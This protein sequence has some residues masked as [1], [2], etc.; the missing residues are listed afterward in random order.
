M[1][2]KFIVVAALVAQCAGFSLAAAAA[3]STPI[4]P[5]D[6]VVAVVNDDVIT[7]RDLDAQTKMAVHQLQQQNTQLPPMD[8][9]QKQVLERMINERILVQQAKQ[10]GV[11]IDDTQLDQALQRIAAQSRMSVAEFRAAL[12]K[13][14]VSFADFREDIRNEMM[15]GRLRDHEVDS[16]VTVSDGEVQNFLQAYGGIAQEDYRIGHIL[17]QLPDQAS[18]DQIEA[19]RL[20]AEA[21]RTELLQGKDFKQ[22]AAAY[23]D[24]PDALQGGIV[25]RKFGQL[26]G[27][28]QQTVQNMQS[29]DVSP[30]L[31]SPNGF[32]VLKLI[33]KSDQNAPVVVEQT[34]ARHILMRPTEVMSDA[35]VQARLLQI[36]ERILNGAKFEE[37]ARLNSVDGSASRGGD[38]GWLSPGDTVPEFE[39]AM[40]ALKPGEISMPIHSQFGWHLIQV[41]ERRQQDVTDNRRKM[42]ARMALHERKADQAFQE[43]V[44]QQRDQAYVEIRLDDK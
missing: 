22:V 10:N 21:A 15:I 33:G 31:R 40:N 28:F 44:R 5:L 38:L 2:R 29:G 39:Q 24:A 11:R 25:Q 27:L 37:M 20:K 17:V 6:R 14:G 12:E 19:A 1:L 4:V 32:H 34:H 36:R 26:P 35:D 3:Q 43:Y 13:D 41:L 7:S 9:L 18:S 16:R 30:V 42:Q 8:V 23:S